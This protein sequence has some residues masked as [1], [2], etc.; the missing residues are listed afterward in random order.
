VQPA[1][2]L[3]LSWT[4]SINERHLLKLPLVFAIDR[5]VLQLPRRDQ[6]RPAIYSRSAISLNIDT[7]AKATGFNRD[8]TL[9]RPMR[10]RLSDRDGVLFVRMDGLISISLID[11]YHRLSPTRNFPGKVRTDRA[12][13]RRGQQECQQKCQPSEHTN[14]LTPRVAPGYSSLNI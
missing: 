3:N 6:S 8:H 12:N 9:C 1:Q 5:R 11:R 10:I 14:I 2:G 7:K 13:S 4:E